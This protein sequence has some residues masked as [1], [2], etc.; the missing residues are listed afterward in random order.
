MTETTDTPLPEQI[1][2][3]PD[4]SAEIARMNVELADLKERSESFRQSFDY[5]DLIAQLDA[6]TP[7]DQRS[8]APADASNFDK[9]FHKITTALAAAKR[10][11]VP[12]TDTTKPSLET[13]AEDLSSLPP[14]VRIARGYAA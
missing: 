13:P 11:V 3:E 10:P 4:F 2:G 12:V 5:A 6:I 8:D 14:H 7:E 9:V 1:D